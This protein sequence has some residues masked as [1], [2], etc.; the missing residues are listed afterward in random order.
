MLC[1]RCIRFILLLLAG[2]TTACSAEQHEGDQTTK[3]AVT[4]DEGLAQAGA[5]AEEEPTGV[6][7]D[8]E[9][10]G[11]FNP[12][13]ETAPEAPPN[14]GQILREE[15]GLAE[16]QNSEAVILDQE[17]INP[18]TRELTSGLLDIEINIE[19]TI[20]M[21]NTQ[22]KSI[23]TISPEVLGAEA[24][25]Q[26]EQ[27]QNITPVLEQARSEVGLF[28]GTTTYFAAPKIPEEWQDIVCS[29]AF[30]GQAVTTIG[31]Y[32]TEMKFT[33]PLPTGVSPNPIAE[34]F[35]AELGDF[36]F[37]H[38][39]EAE[40]I[41]TNNPRLSVGEKIQGSV[42]IEKLSPT[43]K[44]PDEQLN[45]L[46]GDVAYRVTNTFRNRQTTSDLGMLL[47]SEVYINHEAQEYIHFASDLGTDIQY[48][49]RSE[50]AATVETMGAR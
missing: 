44:V 3:P 9:A 31:G 30:A 43:R 26:G 29:V 16:P 2:I 19:T 20:F 41:R 18:Y 28:T 42:F 39:I 15:C 49:Y 40:I 50:D 14:L 35:E 48:L 23:F 38:G 36:R 1:L 24:I 25:Y 6:T 33:P 13:P 17:M 47:W 8:E 4:Q 32:E 27:A 10:P 37:F 12:L 11:P 34:R 46:K 7:S 45:E 5:N 22:A 21:K